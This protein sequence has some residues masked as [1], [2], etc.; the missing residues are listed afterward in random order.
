MPLEIE[1][2]A[3]LE[4]LL[5]RARSAAS[6]DELRCNRSIC[7]ELEALGIATPVDFLR[8]VS[9]APAAE[10]SSM[11]LAVLRTV[12]HEPATCRRLRGSYLGEHLLHLISHQPIR[13]R[14]SRRLVLEMN[15]LRD[16]Q[17]GRVWMGADPLVAA[18]EN[19]LIKVRRIASVRHYLKL[20]DTARRLLKTEAYRFPVPSFSPPQGWNWFATGSDF[21]LLANYSPDNYIHTVE[22]HHQSTNCR[23]AYLLRDP[24]GRGWILYRLPC[25]ANKT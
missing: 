19:G 1:A 20:V 15:H 11:D 2:I 5:A 13:Q 24:E 22:A 12:S 14:I 4:H 8:L 18:L 7:S 23:D 16:F 21:E 17:E 25:K 3:Q 6:V 9:A 10:R